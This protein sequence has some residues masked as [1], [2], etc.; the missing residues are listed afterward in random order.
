MN[1]GEKEKL[2]GIDAKRRRPNLGKYQLHMH[3][4]YAVRVVRMQYGLRSPSSLDLAPV[5]RALISFVFALSRL[6]LAL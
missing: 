1:E 6:N 2:R 3:R 4:L 5:F